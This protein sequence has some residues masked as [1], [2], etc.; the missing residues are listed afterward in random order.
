LTHALT[1][2]RSE[3]PEALQPFHPARDLSGVVKL[4]QL[5][6]RD[7]L[8]APDLAWLRELGTLTAGPGWVRL[9]LSIVPPERGLFGGFVW[10]ED[11]R[12]AGNVSLMRLGSGQWVIA[13]VATHPHYRRRGIA[14]ALMVATLETAVASRARIVGLQVRSDNAAARDL[15]HEL[16][17]TRMGA[18]TTFRGVPDPAFMAASETDSALLAQAWRPGPS[19]DVRSLLARIGALDGPWPPGPLRMS[20]HRRGVGARLDDFLRGRERHGW[21]VMDGDRLAAIAVAVS[22][23]AEGQLTLEA[24]T[25]PEARGHAEGRLLRA[26][27]ASAAPRTVVT[28]EV[29]EDEPGV[30]AVV[31]AAG[32]APIRTL[33]RYGLALPRI[34]GG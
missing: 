11:G 31:E 20:I 30:R 9:L 1:L 7:E 3:V 14:R 25:S 13:N 12:I 10:Y 16:G 27:M 18:A 17:F 26:A 6:F 32:L 21:R 29:P 34:V 33:D 8:E 15:Y 2:T 5:V 24:A 23:A 22:D 28:A 19:P 4:L